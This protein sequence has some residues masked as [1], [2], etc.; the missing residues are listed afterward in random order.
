M[1]SEGK[2]GAFSEALFRPSY[3]TRAVGTRDNM[4]LLALELEERIVEFARRKGPL[5]IFWFS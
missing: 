3:K 2:A 1:N 4:K 5:E